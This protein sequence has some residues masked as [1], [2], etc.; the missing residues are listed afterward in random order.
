MIMSI[1]SSRPLRACVLKI[2]ILP[3]TTIELTFG[4]HTSIRPRDF[5]SDEKS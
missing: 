3:V 5:W 2:A 1:S 4:Q